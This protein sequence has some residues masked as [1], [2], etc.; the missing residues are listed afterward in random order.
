MPHLFK[1]TNLL[2]ASNQ[3]IILGFL[4]SF[5]FVVN[6]L[7]GPVDRFVH[8]LGGLGDFVVDICLV[9]CFSQS[10]AGALAAVLSKTRC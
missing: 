3:L 1:K 5:E 8:E 2:N 7:C 6:F 10:S 9:V 4:N